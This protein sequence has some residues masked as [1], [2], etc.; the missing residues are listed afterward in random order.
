MKQYIKQIGLVLITFLSLSGCD[1]LKE[2]SEDLLIPK[3]V[4]EFQPLLYAEG[5]PRDFDKVAS[6]LNLM[7][8]DIE[9]NYLPG[10][11]DTYGNDLYFDVTNGGN[12]QYV[13]IWDH[14]MER[15]VPDRLWSSTYGHILGTN[16]IIDALPDMEYIPQEKGKYDFLAAQAY[17]LRAYH[18]FVLINTYAK[19]YS[20][21]NLSAP[22]VVIRTLPKVD[23]EPKKRSS[24]GE[25]WEFINNDIAKAQEYMKIA[26]HSPNKHLMS[27]TAL[28]LLA[29]RVALFQEKWDDVIKY[30]E[31]VLES[32]SFIYD[33]N[34]IDEN[35]L[36]SLNQ[37]DNKS[38]KDLFSVMN[39]GG[40]NE[41]IFTFGSSS[42]WYN[43]LSSPPCLFNLGFTTSYVVE[44]SLIQSYE[45][46]D[47][48]VLAYFVQDQEEKDW[49]T[50][51][52]TTKYGFSYP[53][54][55]K[56][57]GNGYHE[58]WR[59]VEAVLNLAEAYVRKSNSVSQKA[60]D[61]LNQLRSKRIKSAAYTALSTSDFSGAKDLTD[62]IW[63]ERRRELCFEE[64]M[65]F[66]DLRRQGM[67]KLEHKRLVSM[68]NYETYV[69]KQASDNY[70]VQIPSSETNYNDLIEPN[71]REVISP[72]K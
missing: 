43:Y 40:N 21:E 70:T 61:L 25:V 26:T 6:W 48:R 53:I 67:P 2:S 22:G 31:E 55:Y 39:L 10:M 35:L 20:K 59:T 47:L 51:K 27:P 72:K 58:N 30:S 36:G 29:S 3:K 9:L 42:R 69:L 15:E 49:W 18:Y 19:P 45:E 68:N 41:I 17:A 60:I 37:R 8:D 23:I 62:F 44:G 28:N 5:Y 4:E 14:N 32:N 11:E 50:G 33:F 16:I 52:I 54:K 56:G 46:N 66:W 7:T 34:G 1:Y 24:I 71:P 38:E 57:V 65:R 64:G 63:E 12:G 13:F